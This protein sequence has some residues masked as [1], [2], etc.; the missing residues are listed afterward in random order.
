MSAGTLSGNGAPLRLTPCSLMT[1]PLVSVVIPCYN[2]KRFLRD[3]VDSALAQENV[4]LDVIIVDDASTDGSGELAA[5]LA[6]DDPRIRTFI[7]TTNIGHIA[8]YN[9]GLARVAGDYVVLLSADDLLGP[10]SLARAAALMEQHPEVGLVYGYAQEFHDTPL[11]GTARKT[12]W[13][14]WSGEDWIAHHCRRGSN[15]I[16]NP[17]AVLRRSVM[18]ELVGY[19]AD[20]PQAADMDLWLRA[21]TLAAVGRINGPV[22]AYYR[23]H[24][25]NMHLTDFGYPL[26]DIRARRDVFA[27]ICSLPSVQSMRPR[28]FE[29][30]ARRAMAE[31][32]VWEAIHIFDTRPDLTACAE[33]LADFAIDTE[34]AI[35]GSRLWKFYLRRRE[36]TTYRGE[37][38]I[39]AATYRWRWSYRWRRWRRVGI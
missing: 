27:S 32:A 33:Q 7:H 21:A 39:F 12:S 26:D 22:Q 19:R 29:N 9:D 6:A 16:V 17:E 34:G 38:A 8:T 20:M 31:E 23:V 4:D 1:R 24:G 28:Q 10:G 30:L 13:S 36:A 5:Q 18:D 2:Y 3:A 14:L 35:T 37:R 11:P 25:Q 15:I